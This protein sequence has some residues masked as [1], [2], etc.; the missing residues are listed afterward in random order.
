M[1]VRAK[2]RTYLRSKGNGK[3]NRRFLRQAQDRLFG[4]AQDR[5]FDFAQ[6]GDSGVG[7]AVELC[8]ITHPIGKCAERMGH[9]VCRLFRVCGMVSHTAA[10]TLVSRSRAG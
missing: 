4:F 10:S 3:F 2:A 5:L 6:D 7:K 9:P 8:S 1:D